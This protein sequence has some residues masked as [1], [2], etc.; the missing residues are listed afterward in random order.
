MLVVWSR[1]PCSSR[2]TAQRNSE[3][4]QGETGEKG[5]ALRYFFFF[6]S[7]LRSRRVSVEA[8][9]LVALCALRYDKAGGNWLRKVKGIEAP[10]SRPQ[11]GVGMVALGRVERPPYH[12]SGLPPI[13]PLASHSRMS[14]SRTSRTFGPRVYSSSSQTSELAWSAVTT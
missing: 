3:T 12:G 9:V 7:Y 8:A 5:K 6:L 13:L 14:W 1:S 2:H 11:Y 10:L 4:P